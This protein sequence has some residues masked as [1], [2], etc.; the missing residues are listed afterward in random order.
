MTPI[1]CKI[2]W[3]SDDGKPTPDDNPAIGCVRRVGY[4]EPYA[5]ALNGFIEYT[6]TEWFPICEHHRARMQTMRGM[7]YWEFRAGLADEGDDE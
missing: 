5:A 4:R 2:Q 1:T 6:T 3:I 7:Q